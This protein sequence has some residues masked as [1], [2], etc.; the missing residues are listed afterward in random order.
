[1]G[2]VLGWRI[3]RD[4]DLLDLG[5]ARLDLEQDLDHDLELEGS[6]MSSDL[7]KDGLELFELELLLLKGS[8]L[9]WLM[10][11]PGFL[12]LFLGLWFFLLL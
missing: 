3:D 1:V 5:A 12:L 7:L 10:S 11:C 2:L 9:L 4:Q 8:F 6:D